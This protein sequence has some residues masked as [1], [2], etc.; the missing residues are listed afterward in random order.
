MNNADSLNERLFNLIDELRDVKDDPEKLKATVKVAEQ[1]RNLAE[2]IIKNTEVSI[3]GQL[4]KTQLNPNNRNIEF[5]K[6]LTT[7][8]E[9]NINA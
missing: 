8:N 5:P 9:G 3:K 1:T 2:T 4:I 6:M 7:S